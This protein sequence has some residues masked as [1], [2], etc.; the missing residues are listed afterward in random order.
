MEYV[1]W[2]GWMALGVVG[3]AFVI[4]TIREEW[5]ARRH[6]HIPVPKVKRRRFADPAPKQ[7]VSYYRP[8][9]PVLPASER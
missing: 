7:R 2:M 3:L 4:A 9:N 6:G 1:G 8:S 5:Y